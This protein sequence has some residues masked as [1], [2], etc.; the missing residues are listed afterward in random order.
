MGDAGV[1]VPA[2]VLF[3]SPATAAEVARASAVVTLVGGYDGSGN[4]GDLAQLDAALA[5]LDRFEPSLLLLPVLE[6][7]RLAEHRALADEF[8]H[9]PENVLFF[10]P[11]EGYQDDLQPIGAPADLAFAG[12]YLYGGGYLNP[13]WGERKLA[14]LAATER[15][16]ADGGAA[17]VCRVS[18]G[19]Q[20]DAGWL[21]ALDHADT[22]MLRAFEPLGSRDP[23]STEAFA[24][25]VGGAGARDT[26]D[27]AV[28]LLRHLR[29]A[30]ERADPEGPA[31]VNVH[32]AE[33]PW[34]TEGPRA[35]ADLYAG[36]LAELERRAGRPIAAQPLLAYA[37]RWV[38]DR[39]EIERLSA[40]CAAR[41]IEVAEPRVLRPAGLAEAAGEMR[42]A[43]LT[44]SCSYHVAL[45]SLL[46]GV[47]AAL[48]GDN[49]YYRQ[50]AAG[51]GEAF[52]LPP[53]FAPTSDADPAVL[54]DE[55]AAAFDERRREG[56]AY[57]IRLGASRVR[58]TRAAAEAELLATL[59]SAVARALDARLAHATERLRERSTEPAELLA[60]LALLESE[61]GAMSPPVPSAPAVSEEGA[62][63]QTLAELLGSRSWRMTAPFRR[64]G[65]RFGRR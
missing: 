47:P 5:L 40:V 65:G 23:A 29:P 45:T 25:L 46:L 1:T 55:L 57:A 52:G 56:L 62:A 63:A 15:L 58:E 7:S 54:A 43:A 34:V 2:P 49:A 10:D 48:F 9:R 33:H 51:L 27:D 28:G 4:Y 20:A 16:L 41:G 59:G 8:L 31:R 60:R 14:M 21:A 17:E 32:V 26:A 30:E 19:L 6:R 37:D 3:A 13:S 38:T 39:E 18:S 11:G 44:L 24:T 42:R 61:N 35:M 12:C 53:A 22:Q 64:V 50:K 36:V